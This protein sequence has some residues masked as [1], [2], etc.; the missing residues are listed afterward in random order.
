MARPA[1]SFRAPRAVYGERRSVGRSARVSGL[2]VGRRLILLPPPPPLKLTASGK[3]PTL[4][5]PIAKASAAPSIAQESKRLLKTDHFSGEP[6][7][8]RRGHGAFDFV[9]PIAAE[10]DGGN[11]MAAVARGEV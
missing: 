3:L 10:E 8:I 4:K 11:G 9:E 2:G 1:G 7:G 6:I 5:L